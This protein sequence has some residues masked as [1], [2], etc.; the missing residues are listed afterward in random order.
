MDD[1]PSLVVF[2][3]A[4]CGI[5]FT[6]HLVWE[7]AHRLNKSRPVTQ[8]APLRPKEIRTRFFAKPQRSKLQLIENC[9]CQTLR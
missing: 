5:S 1:R 2:A 9:D 3:I 4:L 7:W 6:A 8:N